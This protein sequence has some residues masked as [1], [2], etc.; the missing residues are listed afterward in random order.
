M[1]TGSWN[2]DRANQ[3]KVTLVFAVPETTSELAAL[4]I[5]QARTETLPLHGPVPAAPNANG[6]RPARAK[7]IR[8]GDSTY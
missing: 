6:T 4:V 5:G 7:E 8:S 1:K 2:S 3:E